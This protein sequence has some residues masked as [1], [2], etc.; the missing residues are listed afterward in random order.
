MVKKSR[1]FHQFFI[2]HDRIILCKHT[3]L[4]ETPALAFDLSGKVIKS[5]SCQQY[6][7]F[8]F[9]D[10][11]HLGII[12]DSDDLNLEAEISVLFLDKTKQ[13]Y[14][15]PDPVTCLSIPFAQILCDVKLNEKKKVPNMFKLNRIQSDRIRKYFAKFKSDTI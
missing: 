13:S 9:N 6:V 10:M 1:S 5:W 8:S 15:F 2:H 11:W 7:A 3:S 12:V 14:S 4:D